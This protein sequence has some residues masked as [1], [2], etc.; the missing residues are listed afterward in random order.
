MRK[1][2][3]GRIFI[4]VQDSRPPAAGYRPFDPP[5]RTQNKPFDSSLGLSRYRQDKGKKEKGPTGSTRLPQAVAGHYSGFWFA[6]VF[7]MGGGLFACGSPEQVN[8]GQTL[9][10]YLTEFEKA[11]NW[12]SDSLVAMFISLD[13]PRRTQDKF[14]QEGAERAVAREILT[15]LFVGPDVVR[16]RFVNRRFEVA[17]KEALVTCQVEYLDSAGQKLQ[18]LPES[19]VTFRL[20]LRKGMWRLISYHIPVV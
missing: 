15:Q 11:I 9:R 8:Q 18:L 7:I 14:S 20:V 3:P 2:F 5:R 16:I 10:N 19:T 4:P 1:R 13:P 17:R 12:R 6:L